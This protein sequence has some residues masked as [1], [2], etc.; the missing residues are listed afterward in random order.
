M[1][2]D[3]NQVNYQGKLCDQ[4]RV[5]GEDRFHETMMIELTRTIKNRVGNLFLLL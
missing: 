4:L 3:L 2:S 1:F 5:L